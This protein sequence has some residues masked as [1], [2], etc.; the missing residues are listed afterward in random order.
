MADP[1]MKVRLKQRGIR[2]LPVKSVTVLTIALYGY[3][4]PGSL[5]APVY[6]QTNLSS[7]VPGMAPNL[8]PNLKNPWGMSFS[9]TSPFWVSDQGMNVSTLYSGLG[10]ANQLVVGTPFGPTGQVSN[11]TSDF[12][13]TAG[14]PARF[15]FASLSGTVSGW[16]PTASPATAVVK[17]TAPDSAVY[18]GLASG[19]TGNNNFLYA[20]DFA[21]RK[22][23]VLNGS[24]NKVSLAGNFLDPNV[25]GDYAPYSIE[26]IQGSL[27]VQYARVDAVTHRASEDVNQG[28]VDVYDLN[29]NLQRRL[30]TDTHLSSPWG[31]ALAPSGFGD[32]A[33]SLLV[34]NFGDGAIN[35]FDPATGA[36]RGTLSDALGNPIINDGLWA[37]KFRAPGSGFN[38]NTLFFVAGINDEANG[39]FGTIQAVPEPA[40]FALVAGGCLLLLLRAGRSG[41]KSSVA[42]G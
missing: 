12:E 25:P 4:L 23:D 2:Q 11:G 38:P 1:I 20:T 14:N 15:I 16:N 10:V 37:I 41:F 6:S 26:N 8:D 29:G 5:A 17:F 36:Y 40:N 35:A 21:N 7:D 9:A 31:V 19:T 30:I 39:L 34:G 33:N 28:I 18:T 27:Y 32:F 24:F 22:V 42:R 3:L 13:V